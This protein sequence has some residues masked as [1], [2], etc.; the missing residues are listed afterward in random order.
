VAATT[1]RPR[2]RPRRAR[3]TLDGPLQ[4]SVAPR[5][6]LLLVA[7]AAGAVGIVALAAALHTVLV[8][9]VVAIVLA[10][11][12]E[13]LVNVFQQ[14]GL[15]RGASVGIA[16][17]LV[18]LTL[19]AFAYLLFEPLV[20]ELNGFAKD[21]PR[22]TRE[23]TEGRGRLGFL[24]TRYHIVEKARDAVQGHGASGTAGATLGVVTNVVQTA[25]GMVF[26]A[27]LTLFVAL[28]GRHWFDSLVGLAPD[29]HQPRLRRVGSG[30]ARAV[31]GYVS[32]NLVISVI[33][34]SVTTSI[35]VATHVPYP[36]P[37]GLL[38]AVFDLVPLVGATIGTVIVG[39][40]ALTQGIATAAIVVGAMIVYQ[41]LENHT[42][43]QLVY[44]RTVQLSALA[45]SVS[46][47][48]GAELGGVLGALLGIPAA[49][50]LKV[51]FGELAAWRRERA[52]ASAGTPAEPASPHPA[53]AP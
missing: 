30:V 17:A 7:L 23:L 3:T 9:L 38:V 20:T 15:G 22:L 37:L 43:Q 36:V 46:V 14:R 52:A 18:T 8:E 34:G 49:G 6:L 35:L 19:V 27:F 21:L 13:P 51:V 24:E 4:V 5:T 41:Q 45:I 44:H 12:L 31:G 16:F 33:A 50:A 42:L 47:A 28:G 40:V 2:P 25:G 32:G 11:A 10:M 29:E 53:P 26:V 39:G 48:A 1:E